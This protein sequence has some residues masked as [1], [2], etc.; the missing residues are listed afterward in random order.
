MKKKLLTSLLGLGMILPLTVQASPVDEFA[1]MEGFDQCEKP[2][3]IEEARGLGIGAVVGGLLA[4]PA[5][6]FVGGAGGGLLARDGLQHDEKQRLHAELQSTRTELASLRET[7]Q[8]LAAVYKKSL[9]QKARIVE[10]RSVSPLMTGMGMT[11]QFRHDS[12]SLEEHFV[13]QLEQIA[14]NFASVDGL[15]LH[16]SGHAD[17]SGAETYNDRLSKSRVESVAG[18]LSKAGWPADRIHM[19]SHGERRPLS[20]SDDLKGY[21]FDRRVIITFSTGGKGA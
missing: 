3:S 14:R 18:V 1:G 21:S 4:G 9:L 13:Q 7:H 12:A 19:D 20:H 2:L 8:Q 11:V 17:R 16:L 5:G 15:Q 6:V 10:S